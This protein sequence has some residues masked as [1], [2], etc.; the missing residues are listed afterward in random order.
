M[1]E[2]LH[3][4]SAGTVELFAANAQYQAFELLAGHVRIAHTLRHA[5]VLND[6][7]EQP[8]HVRPL[9]ERG[10]LL[11]EPERRFGV[12]AC[13]GIGFGHGPRDYS[14]ACTACNRSACVLA[15]TSRR[16]IFSA[17]AIASREICERSASLA[18]ETSCSI[19]A[20][21]A[22]FSRLPSSR[23]DNFASSIIC[24]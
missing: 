20:L 24:D 16:N 2:Y 11:R 13:N 21:A 8:Q 23:A 9:L 18:R 22:V 14:S 10:L 17:P 7:V 3:K 6:H 19:S 4:I 12:R 5:H 15:S 1:H